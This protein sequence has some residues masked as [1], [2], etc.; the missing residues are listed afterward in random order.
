MKML[1]PTAKLFVCQKVLQNATTPQMKPDG[2]P[3]AR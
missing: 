3:S 2:T 1:H